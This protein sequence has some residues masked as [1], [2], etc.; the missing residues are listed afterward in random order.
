VDELISTGQLEYYDRLP[1]EFLAGIEE[2]LGVPGV[3]PKTA[4]AVAQEFGIASASDLQSDAEA[5]R[6]AGLSRFGEKAAENVP[7]SLQLV[8]RRDRSHPLGRVR[9]KG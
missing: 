1:A 7:R 9:S 2:L 3:G 6:L 4:L 8:L 5:G